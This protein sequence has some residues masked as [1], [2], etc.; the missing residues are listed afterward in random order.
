MAKSG[1]E[2]KGL[3][4]LQKKL[5]KLGED[6]N[7]AKADAMEKGAKIIQQ[8]TVRRLQQYIDVPPMGRRAI[9]VERISGKMPK[10]TQVIVGV[11][12]D[13]VLYMPRGGT[14]LKW[15]MFGKPGY[16]PYPFLRISYD[17]NRQQ[18]IETIKEELRKAIMKA[19]K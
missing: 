18:V 13:Y 4:E 1:I 8:D 5:K 6:V 14:A 11:D 10:E 2:I 19:A 12:P 7:E 17:Q 15:V 3:K 9:R 16:T